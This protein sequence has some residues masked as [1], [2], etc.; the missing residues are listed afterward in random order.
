MHHYFQRAKLLRPNWQQGRF[1]HANRRACTTIHG[2]WR[3]ATSW[4][5]VHGIRRGHELCFWHVAACITMYQK[6]NT[7]LLSYDFQAPFIPVLEF[8]SDH[9]QR[10]T[11]AAA[12]CTRPASNA[13]QTLCKIEC[14]CWCLIT[15]V[16]H[17]VFYRST[18]ALGKLVVHLHDG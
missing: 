1:H 16:D 6:S 18:C 13:Q 5:Q 2:V 4:C 7:H 11:Q 3:S 15:H 14:A 8:I 10:H 12:P 9:S 17:L